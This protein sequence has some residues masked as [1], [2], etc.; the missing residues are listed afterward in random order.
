MKDDVILGR[1]K[2]RTEDGT[3]AAE[4]EDLGGKT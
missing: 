3:D 1:V 2:I 4:G